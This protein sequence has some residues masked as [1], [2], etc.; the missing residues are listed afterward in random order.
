VWS[1]SA[2]HTPAHMTKPGSQLRVWQAPWALQVP[3]P[4]LTGQGTP[5]AATQLPVLVSQV[6]QAGQVGQAQAPPLQVP[7]VHT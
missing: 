6:R 3:P 7:P 5:V 2:V 1:L 4:W